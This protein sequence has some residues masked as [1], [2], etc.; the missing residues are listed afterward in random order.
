VFDG[1][2]TFSVVSLVSTV[3]L[4]RAVTTD[5][6]E[7]NLSRTATRFLSR[8]FS[9]LSILQP[10]DVLFQNRESVRI[11]SGVCQK[12]LDRWAERAC[13]HVSEYFPEGMITHRRCECFPVLKPDLRE[14][15][16]RKG[17]MN[18]TAGMGIPVV[19]TFE[20]PSTSEYLLVGHSISLK[21]TPWQ[22]WLGLGFAC[23]PFFLT[24]V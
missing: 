18:I 23:I 6:L 16:S 19:C 12:L 4:A 17:M 13:N 7:D 20:R 21:K 11:I 9:V 5:S 14:K 24:S 1:L 22:L 8:S 10:A 3:V 15:I 2:D